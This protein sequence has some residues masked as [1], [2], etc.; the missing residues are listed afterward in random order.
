MVL[1]R[2]DPIYEIRRFQEAMNRR[3]RESSPPIDRAE[4]RQWA[5]PVDVV[6]EGDDLLLRASLPGVNPDDI[7]VSIEDRVLTIKA[8]TKAEQER[9]EGGYLIRERRSG[10]FHRS[11][12]LPDTV[13]T[14]KAKTGYEN[15]VLTVALPKAESK[16]A[17]HLKIAVGKASEGETK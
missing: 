7:D 12:R 13:D 17:K 14:D 15:G 2:W 6:E 10:S 4:K 9:K 11:L 3:W 8:E 16:K 1:Q 5:I